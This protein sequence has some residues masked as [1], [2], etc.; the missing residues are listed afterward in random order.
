VVYIS[1]SVTAKRGGIAFVCGQICLDELHLLGAYL[2]VI[3][4]AVAKGSN[5]PDTRSRLDLIRAECARKL[6]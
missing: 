5:R 1:G 3:R 4:D 6:R 2:P